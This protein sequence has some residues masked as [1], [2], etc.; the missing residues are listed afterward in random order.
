MGYSPRARG[1]GFKYPTLSELHR[2]LFG[3]PPAEQLH[4]ALADC[5][6][7]ERCVH[8]MKAGEL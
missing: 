7:T 3:Y 5:R 8:A 2:C 4:D 1:G 6:V